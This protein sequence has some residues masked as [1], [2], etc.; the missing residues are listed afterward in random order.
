MLKDFNELIDSIEMCTG[1]PYLYYFTLGC[2]I[3]DQQVIDYFK[4][5][6]SVIVVDRKGRKWCTGKRV[7]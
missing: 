6:H 5:E 7:K 4:N 3:P 1:Q 2:G